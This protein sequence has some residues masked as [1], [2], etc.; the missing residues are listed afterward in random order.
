MKNGVLNN[1]EDNL[2]NRGIARRVIK[3]VYAWR[4]RSQQ[5]KQLAS[6]SEHML[7]DMGLTRYEVDKEVDKPFWHP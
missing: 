5:R 6:L 2:E 3:K 4:I 1:S 7:K